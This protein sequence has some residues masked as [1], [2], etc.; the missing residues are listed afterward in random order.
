MREKKKR[1][2]GLGDRLKWL[3]DAYKKE[4]P[5]LDDEAAIHNILFDL[6]DLAKKRGVDLDDALSTAKETMRER[7]GLPKVQ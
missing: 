2:F 4:H 1:T 3:F 6:L 5:G 7:D